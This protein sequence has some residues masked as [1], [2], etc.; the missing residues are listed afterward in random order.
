M[1]I[2][3][4]RRGAREVESIKSTKDCEW[5]AATLWSPPVQSH[6]PNP[7]FAGASGQDQRSE[8]LSSESLPRDKAMLH[9]EASPPNADSTLLIES[10]VNFKTNSVFLSSILP[11]FFFVDS[12]EA[13]RRKGHRFV[14]HNPFQLLSSCLF[15]F[16]INCLLSNAPR[17]KVDY[18]QL[19]KGLT[20]FEIR[21]IL[22]KRSVNGIPRFTFF[23]WPWYELFAVSMIS[24][25]PAYMHFLS[26]TLKSSLLLYLLGAP[27]IFIKCFLYANCF[28]FR[29]WKSVTRSAACIAFYKLRK[30]DKIR[31]LDKAT[32]GHIKRSQTCPSPQVSYSQKKVDQVAIF[33]ITFKPYDRYKDQEE[34]IIKKKVCFDIDKIEIEV[35]ADRNGVNFTM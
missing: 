18:L 15:I 28:I 31:F 19:L 10:E 16:I 14:I 3:N 26:R 20:S 4:M 8:G 32:T 12:T 21:V 30:A 29:L 9:Q 25:R 34:L 6:S 7:H 13:M 24:E 2:F 35:I 17:K 33:N 22:R 27:H 23:F 5:A 11:D 1:L